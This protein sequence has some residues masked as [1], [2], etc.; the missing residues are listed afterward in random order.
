MSYG[1]AVLLVLSI[2]VTR[3]LRDDHSAEEIA[4]GLVTGSIS[5]SFFA[6]LRRKAQQTAIRW[7]TI[8][9]L[10]VFLIG[11]T[12][13]LSGK[14]LTAERALNRLAQ[15]IVATLQAHTRAE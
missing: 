13:L 15:Q 6:W 9:G 3:I 2:G 14:H 11:A 8:A 1:V 10:V 4:L 12:Y 5:I 7:Q